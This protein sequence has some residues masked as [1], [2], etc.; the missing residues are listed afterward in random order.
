MNKNNDLDLVM[1]MFSAGVRFDWVDEVM[2]IIK[3][4]PGLS[5]VNSEG[6]LESLTKNKNHFDF[7]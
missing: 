4:R 2:A 1:R 6:F 5:S 3:P 7:K